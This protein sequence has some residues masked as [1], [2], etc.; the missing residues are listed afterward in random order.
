MSEINKTYRIRANVGSSN[1]EY[2]AIDANLLQDYDTIDILSLKIDS[3]DMYKLHNSNYG[4]VVGRVL[5]NNGFGVPNAKLSIF[6]PNDGNDNDKVLELYP[7]KGVLSND[8]NGNRYNLLPNEKISDCHQIAGTFPTKRYALDND[9]VLEVF[10]K[11]YK[12]TTT[13][14]NAGDYLIMGVPVGTHVLHM[15]LDLSD[16]GILSQK[17]RDFVYKGYTI[18]QFENPNKFKG[19]TEYNELS[20]IFSQNQSINVL[21]FWG[22]TSLGE[23]IGLTRAD[24]NVNFKFEPTCVFMGSVVSDNS[25]QGISKKCIPTEEMGNMEELVTGEGTIEMIRKT[26]GGSVEEFQVKG[27]QLINENGIWCYQIPMNL[28][29]MMTD[30]YGNMVPT[31]DPNK[32]IPT[33]TRVRFRISMQDAENNIDN[34]FRPKVLVPHN[35]QTASNGD[36]ERYDYE[37]GT[38]TR[39]DSYRDLFWNNVYSVKSYIPRFQKKKGWDTKKFTGIKKCNFY[40]QNNPIPYNNIR[41]KLPFMFQVMCTLIKTFVVVIG[42]VNYIISLIAMLTSWLAEN[43]LTKKKGKKF[44]DNYISK[45]T[46][47]VMQGSMCPD[48]E[49]WYFAPVL[50]KKKFKWLE[51]GDRGSYNLFQQTIDSVNNLDDM[52]DTKSIDYENFDFD[53]EKTCITIYTDYL[54]HCVELNLAMEYRVISF[55]FYNDW[56]NGMIYF[57][58]F[59]RTVRPRANVKKTKIKGCMDDTSIYSTTR[60]YT[61]QCAL[62][63]NSKS[64][65]NRNVY[66]DVKRT[67]K[68]NNFHK[69]NGLSQQVIFGKNGGICHT[70][71]TFKGQNVYYMKPCEWVDNELVSDAKVNLYATDIILL[72]SLNDCDINGIPQAFKYLSSTSYI[73]PTNLALTNMDSNSYIYTTENGYY[74]DGENDNKLDENNNLQTRVTTGSDNISS[75]ILKNDIKYDGDELS[76]VIALTES[77]GISWNYSGPGQGENNENLSYF[78]GGHF[79]GLSCANSKTNVKSCINLSRICE[80]GV[81]MSQ[82]KDD[83]INNKEIYSVPTGFISGNDIVAPDFRTMF[84][85]LNHKRLIATKTNPLTGYKMYDFDYLKPINFDGSFSKFINGNNLYN[86]KVEQISEDER[87]LSDSGIMPTIE[88]D[89]LGGLET[90]ETQTRTIEETSIDYYLYRF[91]LSYDDLKTTNINHLRKFLKR[92]ENGLYL[93]QYNNSYYFYFGLKNGATALDEFNKQFFAECENGKLDIGEPTI[94]IDYE[95]NICSNETDITVTINNITIPYESIAIDY[96]ENGKKTTIFVSETKGDDDKKEWLHSYNF[97]L[98]NMPIS[99]YVVTVTDHNGNEYKESVEIKLDNIQYTCEVYDFNYNVASKSK[100][101]D[102]LIY[103][104]GYVNIS[105]IVINDLSDETELTFIIKKGDKLINQDTVINNNDKIITLGVNEIGTYGLYIKYKCNNSISQELFLR[106]IEI[107]DNSHLKL[108]LGLNSDGVELT[109]DVHHKKWWD[110]KNFEFGGNKYW[111][112]RISTFYEIE[113]KNRGKEFTTIKTFYPY[114]NKVVWN[115]PQNESGATRDSGVHNSEEFEKIPP[116]YIV[117]DE[118]VYYPT[119]GFFSNFNP[120]TQKEV[121]HDFSALVYDNNMVMGNYE[122]ILKNGIIQNSESNILG[123]NYGYI[124]KPIPN[125]DIQFHVYNGEYVYDNKDGSINDGLFYPSVTYPSINR[126][127]YAKTWFYIWQDTRIGVDIDNDVPYIVHDE[128]AGYTY[129]EVYNGVTYNNKFHTSSS[130]TNISGNLNVSENDMFGTKPTSLVNI[131]DYKSRVSIYSGFNETVQTSQ[132]KGTDCSIISGGGETDIITYECNIVEGVKYDGYLSM[133]NTINNSIVSDFSK[134]ITYYV[135]N[136]NHINSLSSDKNGPYVMIKGTVNKPTDLNKSEANNYGDAYFVGEKLYV[137]DGEDWVNKNT[138]HYICQCPKDDK[139]LLMQ[140]TFKY[141]FINL[142]DDKKTYFVLCKYTA[143]AM[144]DD[145]NEYVIVTVEFTTAEQQYGTCSFK[146]K[147]NSEVFNSDEEGITTSGTIYDRIKRIIDKCCVINDKIYVEPVINYNIAYK[148]NVES[149]DPHFYWKECFDKH[150]NEMLNNASVYDS[151]STYYG[152][153]VKYDSNTN[154]TLTKIY[155][156]IMKVNMPK[157]LTV[158]TSSIWFV[159]SNNQSETIRIDVLNNSAWTATTEYSW[160]TITP[161]TG[162]GGDYLKVTVKDNDSNNIIPIIRTGTIQVSLTDN[163]D[164]CIIKVFQY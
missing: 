164:S 159:E 50:Y 5:A 51:E 10:D 35:P 31:D 76:D 94:K 124:F 58:R 25:S 96:M 18:E 102:D 142:N 17:P 47:S 126:P 56:I 120:A 66:A 16:C 65:D 153:A 53:K 139:S 104:G 132:V 133:A 114:G 43:V 34:F 87:V 62:G 37:F 8:N 93:P 42:I 52:S 68:N 27:T 101:N 72:G 55:D 141:N 75:E 15:D 111:L 162:I 152:V 103:R 134:N 138:Y 3:V 61:Q 106:N 131:N 30:E 83:I 45:L 137:W 97:K 112:E 70:K 7:F 29:Y 2:I 32:G 40:G 108:Y 158:S 82:R 41:I 24:I 89:G 148:T 23:E 74:C 110:M 154:T 95:S 79:L 136:N 147:N 1:E 156:N 157:S 19:G 69:K 44:Y 155:S 125:G 33:R 100:I 115:Y 128:V 107:K 140:N 71:K 123:T 121:L 67:I 163:S 77:A 26:P 38:L 49:N 143:D 109:P 90:G 9:A 12:Y 22:N 6:I 145:E 88:R 122:T 86:R 4:V 13:T 81:N 130:I 54:I 119:Y 99:D 127:F 39:D 150:H 135:D 28:D 85:T 105:N 117:S 92:N 161:T 151:G 20:Q 91:G 118:S 11:Y 73:M 160:I 78:P 113:V 129:S 57:P 80:I 46:L 14:N 116:G 149:M 84:A 36:I 63:Y 144:Y 146:Y 48:L 21:P 60:R 64:I 98:E 59:M